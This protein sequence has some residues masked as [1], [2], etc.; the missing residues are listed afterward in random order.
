MIPTKAIIFVINKSTESVLL[1]PFLD[2]SGMSN[3]VF[4][5]EVKFQLLMFPRKGDAS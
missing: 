3:K 5:N 1:T 2:S 4:L